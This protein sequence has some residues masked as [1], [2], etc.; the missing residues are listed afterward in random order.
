[1]SRS[2]LGRPP[3]ATNRLQ[4]MTQ[5]RQRVTTRP[6]TRNP[7][8]QYI[9]VGEAERILS[10]IGG[11]ALAVY[12][13]TR[14]TLA[15]L[16]LAALG[17]C[18]TYRGLSGHCDMYHALGVSTADKEGPYTSVPA[19]HGVRV[20]KTITINRPAEDLY[21]FW[22]DLENLPKIM[23][24]LKSVK[25]NGNR[26]HW[27]AQAPLGLSAEWDAEVYT[28]RRGE[29]ISWRSLDGSEVDTAGSVH[30]RP[31]PGGRSTVVRV[32]LKY[33]PPAGKVGACLANWFGEAPE[34]QI[35]EDLRSFKRL[36]EAGETAATRGEPA[37]R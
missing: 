9:N 7:Q 30:F 17:G 37:A 36:M 28:D 10:T 24:H 31:L 19:G 5:Q 21:R 22:R 12:G 29:A 8:Q 27:V 23:R 11:G 3:A 14:G 16:G 15:G 4:D 18:L 26:S 1:M 33:N 20:E 35:E 34:R 32:V 13:L 6:L 2:T 25:V